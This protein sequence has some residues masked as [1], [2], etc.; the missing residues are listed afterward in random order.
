VEINK[1]YFERQKATIGDKEPPTDVVE[2]DGI[3]KGSKE[4]STSREQLKDR[5]AMGALGVWPKLDEEC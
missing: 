4:L 2:A 3:D 5:N 1:V